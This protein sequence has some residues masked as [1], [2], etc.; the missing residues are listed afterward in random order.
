MLLILIYL[1]VLNQPANIVEPDP[2]PQL[3]ALAEPEF[4]PV[5]VPDLYPD[6]PWNE[7][8]KSLKKS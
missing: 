2:E 1:P 7:I 6:S 5:L 8:Q 4:I 3:L